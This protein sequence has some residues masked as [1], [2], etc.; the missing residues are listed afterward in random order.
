MLR[1]GI[2]PRSFGVGYHVR[3]ALFPRSRTWKSHLQTLS[4][5]TPKKKQRLVKRS[6]APQTYKQGTFQVSS[7]FGAELYKPPELLDFR[8]TLQR[9]SQRL[10]DA[11]VHDE[12]Q[13]CTT[14]LLGLSHDKM[15][16]ATDSLEVRT[17]KFVERVMWS[18][19]F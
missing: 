4:K 13:S 6:T 7:G 3:T 9:T 14:L 10:S 11:E 2:L 15:T 16:E 19:G 12:L 18:Y 17:V 8:Q 5:K 1:S